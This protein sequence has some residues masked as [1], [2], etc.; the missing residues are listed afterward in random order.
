MTGKNIKGMKYGL[1]T[2]EKLKKNL[3]ALLLLD[4]AGGGGKKKKNYGEKMKG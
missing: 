3:Q 1:K 2:N 4:G